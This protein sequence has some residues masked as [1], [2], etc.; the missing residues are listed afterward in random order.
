[1]LATVSE[2]ELAG[3]RTGAEFSQVVHQAWRYPELHSPAWALFEVKRKLCFL[4][5]SRL[6]SLALLNAV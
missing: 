5:I 3:I 6:K 1:M 2:P 4:H